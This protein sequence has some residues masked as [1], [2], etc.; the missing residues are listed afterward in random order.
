[1]PTGQTIDFMELKSTDSIYNEDPN[2]LVATWFNNL[3]LAEKPFEEKWLFYNSE[4]LLNKQDILEHFRE[5]NNKIFSD[6]S[7][8][9]L[10]RKGNQ[11]D[12]NKDNFFVIVQ[13]KVKIMGI[14]DGHGLN[15]NLASSFVMGHMMD[16]LK[17]SKRF[18]KNIEELDD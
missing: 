12:K 7:V 8:E 17:H 1:L 11:D 16:Y 15:G 13:G 10:S 6:K 18:Q 2:I 3:G 5:D 14:F 4:S 9:F